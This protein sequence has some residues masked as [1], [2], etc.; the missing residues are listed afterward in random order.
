ML[1]FSIEQLVSDRLDVLYILCSDWRKN[2]KHSY[3]TRSNHC[4]QI[5]LYTRTL[6]CIIYIIFLFD[7]VISIP[8]LMDVLRLAV[9]TVDGNH[10]LCLK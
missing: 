9:D 1:Y 5:C 10:Q 6:L 7:F 3:I 4:T 2:R 8:I